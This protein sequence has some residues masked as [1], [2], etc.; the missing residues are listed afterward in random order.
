M[1][2]HSQSSSSNSIPVAAA[3]NHI[4]QRDMAAA[5]AANYN[6]VAAA[7]ASSRNSGVSSRQRNLPP[8]PNIMHNMNNNVTPTNSTS[9]VP[10]PQAPVMMIPGLGS[11]QSQLTSGG[12][13]AGSGFIFAGGNEQQQRM[14]NIQPRYLSSPATA[15][16][17]Y[18]ATSSQQAISN[19]VNEHGPNNFATIRTT[20]I[21]TKQQK[22]HMQVNKPIENSL[23]LLIICWLNYEKHIHRNSREKTRKNH[24][25]CWQFCWKCDIYGS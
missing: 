22:E 18:A 17:V 19:A 9:V 2:S 7:V 4:Q 14:S 1:F 13:P 16:A 15:A 21:V 8:L 11:S 3:H 23:R 25:H 5:A 24:L 20:S 10:A 6:Q 12:S